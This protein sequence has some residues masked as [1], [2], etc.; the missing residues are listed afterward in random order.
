MPYHI[1][2]DDILTH[3]LSDDTHTHLTFI[4]PYS[5]FLPSKVLVGGALTDGG[6]LIAWLDGLIGPEKMRLAQDKLV[7]VGRNT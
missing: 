3:S 7:Q 4:I 6:A 5:L 1:M 2:L